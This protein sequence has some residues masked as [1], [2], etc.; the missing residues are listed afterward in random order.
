M[1]ALPISA[2]GLPAISLEGLPAIIVAG[3][4]ACGMVAPVKYAMHL[5]GQALFGKSLH[6]W[7][8]MLAT[9]FLVDYS[10]NKVYTNHVHIRKKES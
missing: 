8:I 5:T 3:L 7:G 1:L 10:T 6:L 2:Q 9:L 4:S